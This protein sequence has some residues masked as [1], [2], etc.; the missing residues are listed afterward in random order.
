MKLDGHIQSLRLLHEERGVAATAAN[1]IWCADGGICATKNLGSCSNNNLIGFLQSTVILGY[2]P[3]SPTFVSSFF[4]GDLG[5]NLSS[6][7]VMSL[8]TSPRNW[9]IYG[10]GGQGL[11][12]C[13]ADLV[14]L[15]SF[16]WN[17]VAET[18]DHTEL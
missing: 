7:N 15:E 5:R 14:H 1:T 10:G 4:W 3:L 2:P 18:Y 16:G 9:I 13:Y 17:D 6:A 12:P 8:R 11:T